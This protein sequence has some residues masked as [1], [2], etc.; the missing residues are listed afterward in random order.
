MRY[1]RLQ[2]IVRLAVRLQG[3]LGG[4]TLDDI[5]AEFS[6]SRRT[7][8]RLRDAVEAVF[9]P[10]EIVDAT[11][12][13]Q[14]WRLQS[15]ALRRLV[16]LPA[17]ELAQLAGAAQALERAGL[18]D[19]ATVLRDLGTKLRAMLRPDSRARIESDLETLVHAEGLAMRPGPRPRLDPGLLALV[20]EAIAASRVIAFRYVARSTGRQSRQRVQPYGLLYGNRAFL[21][22]RTDRADEPRLWRLANVS[23][24][25]MTNSGVRARSGVRL[26]ALRQT[27]VRHVPGK[28][29]ES[30]SAV[31]R[32]GGAGRIG[33]SL[34]SGPGHRREPRR[35]TD[36]AL[37]GRR[38]RRDVLAPVHVGG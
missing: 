36:G 22:A 5:A 9:G 34:P 11:D 3:T 6:I 28:T 21:V 37:Q 20:R 19:N 1:E 18:E 8:E 4:L 17:E 10:L 27:F 12:S 2:D 35:L 30:G 14:H 38:N 31:R 23:E 25:R 16:H 32:S 7:A 29:R 33:V 13:K 26:A 15:D 24:A